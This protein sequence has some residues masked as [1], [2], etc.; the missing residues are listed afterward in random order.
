[1]YCSL[2]QYQ[3][4]KGKK[5]KHKPKCK[6]RKMVRFVAPYYKYQGQLYANAVK[7]KGR[8]GNTGVFA[9]D[10]QPKAAA[11]MLR[12]RWL[13]MKQAHPVG[14]LLLLRLF[15]RRLDENIGP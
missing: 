2:Y 1:M 13:A 12:K 9:R 5:Q 15:Q 6:N 7:S 3:K 11:Q 10:R 14:C 4:S 8:Y